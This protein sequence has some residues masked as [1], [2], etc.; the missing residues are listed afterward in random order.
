[1][2][3]IRAGREGPVKIGWASSQANAGKRLSALQTG[4]PTRLILVGLRPG[5]QADEKALHERFRQHRIGGEWF[6]PHSELL[7]EIGV[8]LDWPD[9]WE[10]VLT[11]RAR[12][13]DR[14][15]AEILLEAFWL[16]LGYEEE[17]L[18]LLRDDSDESLEC[19]VDRLVEREFGVP[20]P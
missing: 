13:E 17:E 5:S 2:Y 19:L 6:W 4:S 10:E 18:P 11:N 16:Y 9:E 15:R 3:F 8:G 1:M 7:Q 14:S 20:A 12:A